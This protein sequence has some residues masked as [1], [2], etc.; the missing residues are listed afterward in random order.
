MLNNTFE[1][2]NFFIKIRKYFLPILLI[3]YP[4]FCLIH[5]KVSIKWA[6]NTQE[7][8]GLGLLLA[9]ISFF[10]PIVAQLFQ[11]VELNL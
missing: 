7:A 8:Y 9:A 10:F 4:I 5:I 6:G 2:N 3:V 1:K 11:K